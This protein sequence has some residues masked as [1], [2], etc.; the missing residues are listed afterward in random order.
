MTMRSNGR[1]PGF[2]AF[3][4]LVASLAMLLAFDPGSVGATTIF[5]TSSIDP[6]TVDRTSINLEATYAATVRLSFATRSFKVHVAATIRNTSGGPI[7]RVELN[8]AAAPLGQMRLASTL[9]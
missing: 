6:G 9:V 4:A 8:T 7:D 2:A 5:R 1:A 3:L